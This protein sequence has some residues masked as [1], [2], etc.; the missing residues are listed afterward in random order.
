M[1][2][3]KEGILRALYEGRDLEGYIQRGPK[4]D[5][6]PKVGKILSLIKTVLQFH[7]SKL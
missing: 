3:S 2:I 1:D 7:Y 6:L 4:A 5:Q